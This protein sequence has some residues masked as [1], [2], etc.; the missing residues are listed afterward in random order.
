MLQS[1]NRFHDSGN[2]ACW[3]TM[4]H[5]ALD[6]LEGSAYTRSERPRAIHTEPMCKGRSMDRSFAKNLP[7]A[8]TSSGSPTGVPVPWHSK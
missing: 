3:F 5:V 4:A 8:S 7:M 6:L 2:A 1:K